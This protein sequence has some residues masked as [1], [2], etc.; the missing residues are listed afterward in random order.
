MNEFETRVNSLIKTIKS[1]D[2]YGFLP[3]INLDVDMDSIVNTFGENDAYCL[4]LP[5]FDEHRWGYAVGRLIPIIEQHT[6]YYL[7]FVG[8]NHIELSLKDEYTKKNAKEFA[9]EIID[10]NECVVWCGDDEMNELTWSFNKEDYA[11]YK[12]AII[13]ALADMGWEFTDK[14]YF[15]KWHYHFKKVS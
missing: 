8:H 13:Q 15:N 4:S 1:Y 10:Y 5:D 9:D 12:I 6:K 7:D 2:G 14:H 3:H 11:G